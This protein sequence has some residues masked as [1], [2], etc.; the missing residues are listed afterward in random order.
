MPQSLARVHLHLVFSTKLREPF[1]LD[2][3]RDELHAFMAAILKHA[4]CP[5][6]AMNSV[7]DNI[8]ILFEL[9]RTMAMSRIVEE[10]KTTSSKWIKARGDA[11]GGFAWQ[12]GYGVFAVSASNLV[13]VRNYIAAQ[14]EHH[15]RRSFQDEY[16]MMLERNRVAFD[17]R[18]VWD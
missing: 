10:V 5:V 14:R 3:F 11:F 1:L 13:A 9:S 12:K 15:G 8:H 17:E 16:R 2:A 4:G 18:Y 7:E 6:S